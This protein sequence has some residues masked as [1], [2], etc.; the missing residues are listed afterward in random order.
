M[1]PPIRKTYDYRIL[2]VKLLEQKSISFFIGLLV[3]IGLFSSSAY[4]LLQTKVTAAKPAPTEINQ[5]KATTAVTPQTYQIQEGDYL[6]K[7]AEKVYGSGF[8]AY[9]IAQVNKIADPNNLY[10]GQKLII[11]NVKPR[12]GTAGDIT[13]LYTQRVT[14]KNSTYLVKAG[15]NLS[16]IALQVYG[17]GNMIWRIIQANNIANPEL[18][19]AGTVL[20]IPR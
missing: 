14:N 8:N 1:Q 20:K 9:D 11:P 13:S 15:D 3:F 2:T 18:L 17:D 6:W 10:K 12:Q 16:Q 5:E 7:I 4:Y 19:E